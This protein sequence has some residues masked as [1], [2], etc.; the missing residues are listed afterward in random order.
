MRTM[1]AAAALLS[2]TGCASIINGTSQ[3]I[4]ILSEPAGAEFRVV[5]T[6][7][8][9]TTPATVEL[10]RGDGYFSGA[11]YNVAYSKPGYAGATQKLIPHV[12]G[13]YWVGLFASAVS[14]LVV[15]PI[16]GG[17]WRL[18][19]ESRAELQQVAP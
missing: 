1:L 5:E 18:P 9:G 7:Q 16:S 4:A 6:G 2:L 15:D 8:T 19:D 11:R 12:S 17:M 3:E 14:W 13:W 10:K